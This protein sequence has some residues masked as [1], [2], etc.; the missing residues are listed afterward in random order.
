VLSDLNSAHERVKEC[1]WEP[2]YFPRRPLYETKYKMPRR[3]KDPFRHLMRDYMAMEEE[4]DNRQYGALEDVIA[5]T[6]SPERAQHR[7]MEVLKPLLS[8][9]TCAEY[10][11]VKCMA[12]LIDAVDNP[13]LRQGYLAQMLD[14]M[15]HTNQQTYLLRYLARHAPDP[16]GFNNALQAR[17]YNPLIRAAR[18]AVFDV[19]LNEDPLTCSVQVQMVGEAGY[20]N[21]VFVAATEIAA[22]NDDPATPSVFLNIQSDE[23]R[24]M[25]NGYAT[26]G[27]LLAEPDNVPM[28]QHDFD[29]AFWRLHVFMDNFLGVVYDYF[30]KVRLRSYREYWEQWVWEDW[31]GGYVDR[32]SPFGLEVPAWADRIRADLA[33]GGHTCAML[34]AAMW[35]IHYWRHDV[36][37][38]D[39]F[40][41]LEDK[42]PGWERHFG[43]FWRSY[44]EMSD[45][46]NGALALSL[47]QMP[48]ICRVCHMPAALP[49]PDI[50]D[51]RVVVDTEGKKHALC[52][53]PC[54]TL[55]REAPWRYPSPTWLELHH[56]EDLADYIL[57]MGLVR[58]DGR[59]L[60]GQP[61]LHTDERRL[62]TI[63]DI[64]RAGVEI[65]D[66]LREIDASGL[67]VVG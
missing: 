48:L 58:A 4:K 13:E 3:T 10:A 38:P 63:D 2:E 43:D 65:T 27:A 34:A 30:P 24:H 7:W 16:A 26:L 29:T 22:A 49:R 14:E 11:A 45:P 37:G 51:T 46:A 25:A 39:D 8:M 62:W 57:R 64:R 66:P 19:F 12:S 54:E 33:W 40:E 28:L 15:R 50:A 41:Y 35:P 61:H 20:T 9:T 5:R 6:R 67:P 17:S 21:A 55:F 1:A 36:M 42:Y 31:I 18:G 60:V 47:I 23:V 59:T 44:E 52:S 32:L 53:G 56:G